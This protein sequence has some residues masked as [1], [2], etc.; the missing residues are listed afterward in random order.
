MAA[1]AMALDLMTLLDAP[2]VGPSRVR[3]VL[4]KWERSD[5]A[6]PILD[7]RTLRETL[8]ESQVG[9]LPM[10]RA[11]VE[12]QADDL[13]KKNIHAISIVDAEYP[14][15]LR[16][17]LGDD[18]PL[19][20]LC[21]GNLELLH[22]PGAGFCGSRE[23]SEKGLATARDC[24]GLLAGEGVNIVS[25]F[26]AGVDMNAHRAALTVG[27]TT[28]IVL[29]EGIL[30]FRVKSE[31]RGEWD[32]SRV[33]VVSEFGANLAWSVSN[34]MR[35]NR[36]ICGL[37]QALI[38]IE[39]RSTGGSIQAGRDAL[40]LG[41]PLFAAVYEGMPE[42]ATGNEELLGQ[43]ARRLLKSRALNR[44]NIQPI[45]DVIRAVR[46]FAGP[47]AERSRVAV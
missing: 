38:L 3:K 24:A 30:R 45:L 29:A 34:A 27:G 43:G 33:L 6:S 21:M 8:T 39:A 31:I 20:L 41:L 15:A 25:G 42:S 11:R 12:R 9:A 35:R 40:R 17:L 32:E 14:A 44:P 23:A 13:R 2:G 28:T 36:T 19:V 10:C 22:R 26:A 7:G 5:A 46:P 18:A 16:G 37:A 47:S 4:R 1:G